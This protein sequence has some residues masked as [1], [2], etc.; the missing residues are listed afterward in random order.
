VRAHSHTPPEPDQGWGPHLI[1]A[2]GYAPD[3]GSL[4]TDRARVEH[5]RLHADPTA[6]ALGHSHLPTEPMS[7]PLASRLA[8]TIR[9]VDGSH[10]MSAAALGDHLSLAVADWLRDLADATHGTPSMDNDLRHDL[11]V[12]GGEYAALADRVERGEA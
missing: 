4:T 10:T 12:V 3:Y 8:Q 2:H 11:A 6:R 1:D 7:A 5:E 9:V